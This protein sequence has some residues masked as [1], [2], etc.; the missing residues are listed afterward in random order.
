MDGFEFD[1]Y[2]NNIFKCKKKG[3]FLKAASKFSF[4]K[5]LDFFYKITYN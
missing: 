5:E 1:F 4:I 3:D 2:L